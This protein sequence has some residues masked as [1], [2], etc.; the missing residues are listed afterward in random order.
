MHLSYHATNI[1]LS[2]PF[3]N[4][5]NAAASR[6]SSN[7]TSPNHVQSVQG[8]MTEDE[9]L[10]QA[11]ARSIQELDESHDRNRRNRQQERQQQQTVPCGG[12]AKDKCSLS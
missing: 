11:L 6:Q 8:G 7:S 1:H 12:D 3:H 10:A 5:R 2:F 9:A 4:S